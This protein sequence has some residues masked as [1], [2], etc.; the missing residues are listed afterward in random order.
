MSHKKNS[1]N[2]LIKLILKF[3]AVEEKPNHELNNPKRILI[4]RQHNQFGDMLASVSL[5]R[6]VKETYPDC[7]LTVIVSPQNYNALT[8]NEFI[9]KT[10]IYNQRGF[11]FPNFWFGLIRVLKKNYD[12]V[13]VPA[14][15]SISKTSCLL[16]RF[17]RAE[18]R[19]GPNS[20]D[21][22]KNLLASLFHKRVNLNWRKFP[23]THISDFGLEVLRPI[24]ISTKNYRSSITFDESDI[25]EVGRF[26]DNIGRKPNTSLIGIHVGAGKPQNRWSLDKY[27]RLLQKLNEDYNVQ[28]YV[29]GSNSDANELNYLK[30]NLDVDVNYYLNRP[31]PEV[32]ALISQSDLFVTNDTGV[33]HVAGTTETPQISI[34]GPTNPFNW[35]PLGP[36]KYFLRKSDLIDDVTVS[37]VYELCEM[38]LG[39][40]NKR[41]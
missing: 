17:A 34:F 12:L 13:V 15:V 2:L 31:I 14:T 9:D 7:E 32:A 33:M 5:F 22:M 41:D 6:A 4:V 24:G 18:F 11:F 39:D 19:V 25:E 36:N 21:G 23:D 20:L 35:A 38:I 27:I 16:G 10:F 30:Q 8:K 37:D 3:F 28:F 29:T 40:K 1:S 26:L